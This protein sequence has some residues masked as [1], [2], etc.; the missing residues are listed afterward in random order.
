MGEDMNEL[1]QLISHVEAEKR[2]GVNP[3]LCD[4]ILFLL[5]QE[6]SKQD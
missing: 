4:A 1:E 2:T 3:V 6:L 5:R